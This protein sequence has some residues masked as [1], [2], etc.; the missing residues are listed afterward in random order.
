MY[1]FVKAIPALAPCDAADSSE[2]HATPIY[3]SPEGLNYFGKPQEYTIQS[4]ADMFS[5]GCVVYELLTDLRAFGRPEDK[6]LASDQ[7]R[8][9]VLLRHAAWVSSH[10]AACL[11][12][13]GFSTRSILA[14]YF[15]EQKVR[16]FDPE[17]LSSASMAVYY[18][19]TL[20]VW[21]STT[22]KTYMLGQLSESQLI[23][24]NP[25]SRPRSQPEY[26]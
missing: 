25:S 9:Q 7:L 8:P 11:V 26:L 14:I 12:C 17:L 21:L 5:M 19:E 13:H 16:G 3:T 18:C 24:C 2:L 15:S 20:H 23:C 4:A 6:D 10:P 22:V 1:T